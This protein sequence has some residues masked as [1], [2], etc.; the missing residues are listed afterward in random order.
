MTAAQAEPRPD[1][2]PVCRACGAEACAPAVAHA[3]ME[4]YRCG[5]CGF[6]FLHP[7]P[8]AAAVAALYDDAY[9]GATTSYFTKVD[10]KMRRSRASREPPPTS[11]ECGHQKLFR[12][13]DL[14]YKTSARAIRLGAWLAAACREQDS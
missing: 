2:N 5:G 3:A 14:C 10:S 12:E 8:C 6:V 4:L 13:N 11:P 7:M 9:D 1:R